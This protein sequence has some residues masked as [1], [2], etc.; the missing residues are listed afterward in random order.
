MLEENSPGIDNFVDPV[1]RLNVFQARSLG[2]PYK[3][4]YC[5]AEGHTNGDHFYPKSLGG[6]LKVR[7]CNACN[8][9]KADLTPL[10]WINYLRL[11]RGRWQRNKV[12]SLEDQAKY[13]ITK[14][15]RMIRA[16]LT[17][18]IRVRHSVKSNY[19]PVGTIVIKQRGINKN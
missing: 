12:R 19:C 17:L 13:E 11:K 7:S 9:E 14:L 10:E 15:D 6:R 3:C 16:S 18:W 2:N 5:G 1:R 4:W 8:N